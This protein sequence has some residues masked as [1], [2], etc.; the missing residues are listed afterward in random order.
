MNIIELYK[1]EFKSTP[2]LDQMLN[3]AVE[4]FKFQRDVNDIRQ[5]VEM[6]I[7]NVLQYYANQ[8]GF[9][10]IPYVNVTGDRGTIDVQLIPADVTVILSTLA[11]TEDAVYKK[12]IEVLTSLKMENIDYYEYIKKFPQQVLDLLN[13]AIKD[14]GDGCVDNERIADI[15]NTLDMLYY[16]FRRN[17]GCCGEYEDVVKV[18]G[19]HYRIGFNYGH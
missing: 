16:I 10:D 11:N 14:I 4:R 15:D 9:R 2:E 18:D 5:G 13:K 7:K 1:S 19:T 6:E 3:R 12:Y 17:L 8:K